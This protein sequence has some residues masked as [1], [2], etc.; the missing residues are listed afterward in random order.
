[1]KEQWGSIGTEFDWDKVC[2]WTSSSFIT[3]NKF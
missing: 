2:D 1:M 3:A